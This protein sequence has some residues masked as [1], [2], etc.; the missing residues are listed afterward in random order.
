MKLRE[1]NRELGTVTISITE[2][3]TLRDRDFLLDC[4]EGGGVDNWS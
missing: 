2:Y 3:D 4:L 1:Y